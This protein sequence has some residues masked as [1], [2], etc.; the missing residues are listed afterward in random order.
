M[1][2]SVTY[3]GRKNSFNPRD[4]CTRGCIIIA[5]RLIWSQEGYRQQQPLQAYIKPE[6]KLDINMEYCIG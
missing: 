5:Y 2:S 1:Y 4:K 6:L 3:Y